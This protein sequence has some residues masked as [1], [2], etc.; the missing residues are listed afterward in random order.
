[1]T[2]NARTP[3]AAMTALTNLVA[4]RTGLSFP[5]TRREAMEA[6]IRRAMTRWTGNDA[7]RY[8]AILACDPRALDELANELTVGETYFFREPGQFDFIRR[9]AV[10]DILQHRDSGHRIRAWSA[11]CASG[12]EAYSLAIALQE[13]ARGSRVEVVGTDLARARLAVARHGRYGAWSLRGVPE[14]ILRQFFVRRGAQVE[15]AAPIRSAVQ[16]R[17]LNL[18]E[19]SY[20]SR[21]GAGIW[22]MDLILCRNVLIYFDPPT[23]AGVARRL[24]ESLH[25]GGWLFLG[26]SDPPVAEFTPCEVVVTDAGVAY[27]K[28]GTAA[29]RARRT[30][31][32]VDPT[33]AVPP[34]SHSTL[35]DAASAAT[36]TVALA[37]ENTPALPPLPDAAVRDRGEETAVQYA[38]RDYARAAE[39]ATW[40]VERD[41]ADPTIWCVLVRALAKQGNLAAAADACARALEQHR[42]SAELT[43]LYAMLLCERGHH[44]GA[45]A[46][47]RQALYLDR[48]AVLSHMALGAALART[49]E[50]D[51]ARR[52]LEVA[53][54]LLASMPQAELV[55]WSDGE[56]AGELLELV[57][58]RLT[59]V[60]QEVA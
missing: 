17:Y 20:P 44:Q 4:E 50:P 23:I 38:A 37:A 15:I 9:E 58:A 41:G 35:D 25:D 46:V 6:V 57:R 29:R 13:A 18:A 5:L 30:A 53:E 48:S 33:S 27:R 40:Y 32:T 16:F 7:E 14:H 19:D 8:A 59:L 39:F 3:N 51:G 42:T 1:M 49:G 11:G 12:E 2:A 47:A 36:A 45:V 10:P 21:D 55:P 52:A 24:L 34:A 22:R 54:R 31:A 56:S 60:R 28:A 43:Y 26:A